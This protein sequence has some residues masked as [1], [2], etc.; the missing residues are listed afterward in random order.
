MEEQ[1]Q[2]KTE[3]GNQLSEDLEMDYFVESSAKSGLNAEKIFVKA[4][5]LLFKEYELLKN[6]K[7][8]PEEINK[9]LNDIN[10]NDQKKINVVNI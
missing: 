9:K 4:A 10:K 1:R 2:V 8:R 6:L 5:K 7:E 3:D